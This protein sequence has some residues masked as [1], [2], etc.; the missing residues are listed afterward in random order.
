MQA[1][2]DLGAFVE[3][4]PT[5]EE[6]QKMIHDL[7]EENRIQR[8]EN[9]KIVSRLQIPD[10]T[11][12]ASRAMTVLTRG[13]QHDA[14]GNQVPPPSHTRRARLSLR[15]M[16]GHVARR[17][18]PGPAGVSR[19]GREDRALNCPALSVTQKAGPDQ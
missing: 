17:L 8:E 5:S 15:R 18:D 7:P 14:T 9:E 6:V 4:E 2:R 13:G 3:P 1:E 11:G 10:L 12:P 19:D 16:A